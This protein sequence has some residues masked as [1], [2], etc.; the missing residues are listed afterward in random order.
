MGVSYF[1]C[2]LLFHLLRSG[3][4][5]LFPGW[6]VHSVL[7]SSNHSACRP[8]FEGGDLLDEHCAAGY[9]SHGDRLGQEYDPDDFRVSLSL[10]LK[11]EWQDTAALHVKLS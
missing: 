7:N 8:P 11:G 10:N 6:L 2:K 1:T 9:E 4:L 3:K 5:V